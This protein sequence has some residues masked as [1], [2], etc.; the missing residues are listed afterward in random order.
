MIVMIKLHQYHESDVTFMFRQG[1]RTLQHLLLKW[2]SGQEQG[3]T[4]S[5]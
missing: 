5:E 2:E 4:R 1:Y 3:E